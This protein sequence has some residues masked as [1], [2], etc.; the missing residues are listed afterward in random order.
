MLSFLASFLLTQNILA[1][2]LF[3]GVDNYQKC[4]ALQFLSSNM[5]AESIIFLSMKAGIDQQYKQIQKLHLPYTEAS[6][7]HEDGSTWGRLQGILTE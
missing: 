2:L 6:P 3:L 7:W 4:S 5:L 1:L